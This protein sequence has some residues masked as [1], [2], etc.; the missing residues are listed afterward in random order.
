[1]REIQ[2]MIVRAKPDPPHSSLLVIMR[3]NVPS[4]GEQRQ[5]EQKQPIDE[6]APRPASILLGE[7]F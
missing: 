6:H 3:D 5:G 1:M 2:E 7:I 4:L